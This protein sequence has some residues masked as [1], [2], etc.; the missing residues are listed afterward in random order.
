MALD[1]A[2]TQPTA[3][4]RLLVALHYG[5]RSLENAAQHSGLSLDEAERAAREL[6]AKGY[7]VLWSF[8]D[9][10]ILSMRL[11]DEGRRVARRVLDSGLIDAMDFGTWFRTITDA[12]LPLEAALRPTH[13]VDDLLWVSA[14]LA[15]VAVKRPMTPTF[16]D[17]PDD[18]VMAGHWGH[19]VNSYAI[20]YTGRWQRHRV[21]FRLPYGGV[22]GDPAQDVAFA[23][24]Y[25]AAYAAFREHSMSRFDASTLYHNM[26]ES[27]AEIERDRRTESIKD[28]P[29]FWGALAAAAGSRLL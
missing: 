18:Y 21:F 6:A 2:G 9:N 26:G 11:T 24:E 3:T 19:G 4:E 13:H 28:E 25:L 14:N 23:V 8:N 7:A 12:E 27:F 5:E 10:E 20:Y 29:H 16:L 15:D 22:Y 1:G 17:V